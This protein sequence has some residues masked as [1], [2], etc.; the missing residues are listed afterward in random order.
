MNLIT[1]YLKWIVAVASHGRCRLLLGRKVAATAIEELCW[2]VA[3][4]LLF[5]SP[6]NS[7]TVTRQ[8]SDYGAT[9]IT[10]L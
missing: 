8:E 7:Y 1:F 5:S 6:V 9:N 2:A 10:L 3:V 4:S